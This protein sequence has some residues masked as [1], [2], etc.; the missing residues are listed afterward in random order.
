[1]A[2]K[3]TKSEIA[4][5]GI[6]VSPGIAV[7]KSQLLTPHTDQA[8]QRSIAEEEIP[9]EIA[10][11]EEA[12]IATHDQIKHIQK[13]V[14]EVLGDE[15]ASIFDAHVL[16]VDDRSFIEDVIRRIK[17]DLINVEPVLQSVANRYADM[18]AKVEDSYLAERAADIRDVTK[19]IM[20][21]LAGETL[22]Q[23]KQIKEPCIV[24]A[25]DLSPSDTASI[26]RKM[27]KA[28][29]TDLGSSTSHTAIMA[30][31]LEVPAVVGLHNIS[32][33][34]TSGEIILIDGA[35]GLVFVNPTEERIEEYRVRAQEQKL[36]L[37]DLEQL[38]DKLPETKDGYL[39]PITANIELLEELEGVD[40]RGAK[41]IGLFRTEFLFLGVEKLPDEEDQVSAY[42]EA[43][44]SQ[45]PSP[46]VIRTLDLGADKLP[47]GFENANELNPFLGDRAIRLCLSHPEL[48]KTQL[49]AILRASVHD[50]IRM[51]YPMISC[52]QEVMDANTLLRQCMM[53]L[54]KEGIAFNQDIEIG[55]MIEVPSAA[56]ISDIIAPHVSFFSL[57]TNDLIQYT[58]AVDR[59]N[60]N[61]AHLYNP[62]HM[63]IIRLIDYVVKV[64]Q[65]HGL[66]TCVCGQMAAA[67]QL[68]PLL[69]G[70]GVDELSVSPSQAPMIKD[71]IRKL[72]YSDAVELAQKALNSSSAGHV[73]Q[74]CH[75]LI[76]KIAPEV[77]EISE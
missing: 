8:I 35:K 44:E 30:K 36:I 46:V 74:L 4:L 77:L 59:G 1:V 28:F 2:G 73:E 18:L 66:W 68:V 24:V 51:M 33:V 27:V 20:A 25:H 65:K 17:N 63:A 14:A 55:T 49:R 69:I 13:Q 26:N 64:S 45:Y 67:P 34:I 70:L 22:D 41:G 32:A 31:A 57:G 6:G 5:K 71:V 52:V 72:Y 43:A 11:F 38:R 53:E 40:A 48:F 23:M 3:H 76:K 61:V 54:S 60:E 19:R 56:L 42:V 39:V 16:V 29:V 12:L 9:L 21:N 58:M 15:H 7:F 47:L 37:S 50:N 10:R 62:T 75:D